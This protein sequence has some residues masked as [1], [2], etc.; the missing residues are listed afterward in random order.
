MFYIQQEN[1]TCSLGDV[2]AFKSV[3][4]TKY[5][6]TTGLTCFEGGVYVSNPNINQT[7]R[8]KQWKK[9]LDI[10]KKKESKKAKEKKS[11]KS[12]KFYFI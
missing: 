11:K 7:K 3:K 5:Q 6:N 10:N 1:F 8:I 2:V 12:K 9:M 4:V